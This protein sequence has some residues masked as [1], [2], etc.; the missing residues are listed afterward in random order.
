MLL[1]AD[2]ARYK[3]RIGRYPMWSIAS[4]LPGTGWCGTDRGDDAPVPGPFGT[5]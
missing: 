3:I 1:C 5:G 2:G 4:V